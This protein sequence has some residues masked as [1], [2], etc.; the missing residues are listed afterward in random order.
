VRI[1]LD[2]L[3]RGSGSFSHVYHDDEL[4]FNDERVRLLEQPE[5][6]GKITRNG[7][8]VLISGRIVA[9]AEVDCDR[10]LKS[11]EVPV[12][13]EFNLQYVT[14]ADYEAIQA[15]ELEE[16][17]LALSVFDGEGIDVDEIVR[18]Q[19]LLAVP[20]RTLCNQDC[21]GFCPICG[22]D[23][24]LQNCGCRTEETDP[25]WAGLKELG[26]RKS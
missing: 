3:E 6:S 7:N 15:A 16:T 13:S 21:K 2:S 9:R 10:C 20:T 1:E 8:Q 19:V 22:A 4:E 24:N 14:N 25:R 5:I 12:R 18:E 11:V 23:K 17:D 26:N